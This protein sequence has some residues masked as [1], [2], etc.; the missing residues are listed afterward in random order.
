MFRRGFYFSELIPLLLSLGMLGSALYG[1]ITERVLS[2]TGPHYVF[3]LVGHAQDPGLYWMT[4]T[5]YLLVGAVLGYFSVRNLRG[6]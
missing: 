5:V 6:Y 2:V 3:G 4:I 1:L